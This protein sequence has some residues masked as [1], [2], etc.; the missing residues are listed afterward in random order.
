MRFI[1]R[2]DRNNRYAEFFF[3]SLYIDR[4]PLL[5]GNV[6]HVHKQNDGNVYSGKIGK[7]KQTAVK[8]RSVR[9]KGDGIGFARCDV[10]ACYHFFIG[11]G[12]Q[13][14]ASGQIDKGVAH[15]VPH[16]ITFFFFDGF[17]RP[18]SHV[19]FCTR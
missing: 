14:V 5:C 17:T 12:G 10:F 7:H 1:R 18:I 8:L 4:F 11:I 19:L 15:A 6:H 16:K 13:P 9:D 2:N 3:E